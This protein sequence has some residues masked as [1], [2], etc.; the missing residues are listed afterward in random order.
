MILK[1]SAKSIRLIPLLAILIFCLLAS[2]LLNIASSEASFGVSA[3]SVKNDHMFPGT[4]Y[5]K[6]INLSRGET[7]KEMQVLTE[8]RGDE[9]LLEW[10]TIPDAENL[11]MK[12]GQNSIP[13]KVVVE[14]PKRAAL[15]KYTG[16]IELKLVPVVQET[17][18]G[19]DVAI[20]FGANITVSITV[21]G[22][23]V[24]D[25]RVEYVSLE[26]LHEEEPLSIK[27][28]VTNLGNTD[29]YRVPG[30]IEI[31]DKQQSEVI[32]SLDFIP[33]TDPVLP[34]KTSMRRMVY[35]DVNLPVAEYWTHIS[36]FNN[37]KTIY[38]NQLF[39]KVEPKVIPVIT[40]EEAMAE[41]GTLPKLSEEGEGAE[42]ATEAPVIQVNIPEMKQ[43][44]PS[45]TNNTFLIF[46]LAG[47]GLGL[48]G[49]IGLIVVLVIVL[50]NQQKPAMNG[51]P[52]QGQSAQPQSPP[53]QNQVENK[54]ENSN[55]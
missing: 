34:N 22:K 28:K 53:A 3:I 47:L 23:E 32:R 55:L 21:T 46:G 11:V 15:K 49:V 24:V 54:P 43:A 2:V 12:R 7:D 44:A 37:D 1:H 45:E 33:F 17:G 38:D 6:I 14:V 26:A 41:E 25:Y 19:G 8:I 20:A 5:E 39:L 51:Y 10:I 30:K 16:D 4:S 29:L 50:K 31:Y 35:L 40:P 18:P 27:A 48:I 9:K 36:I 13:M 52:A 42:P